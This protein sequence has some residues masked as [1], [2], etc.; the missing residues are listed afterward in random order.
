MVEPV[1]SSQY[2]VP[3][4]SRNG[5]TSYCLGRNNTLARISIPVSMTIPPVFIFFFNEFDI[6]FNECL[7]PFSFFDNGFSRDKCTSFTANH[8][9]TYFRFHGL[10]FAL[11]SS[12]SIFFDPKFSME[13]RFAWQK[14]FWSAPQAL[15]YHPWTYL[16]D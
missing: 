9:I 12:Q 14:S 3:F 10:I 15:L 11:F 13:F 2:F 6:D 1:F 8:I 5:S 4:L 7:C 16:T